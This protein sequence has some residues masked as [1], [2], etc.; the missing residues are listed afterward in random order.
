VGQRV[1]LCRALAALCG[2]TGRF[3]R[4]RSRA[5]RFVVWLPAEHWNGMFLARGYS[6]YGGPMD[7]V[8]LAE[9]LRLGYATA[10]TDGGGNGERG[11]SFLLR[12]REKLVDVGE[13]AR[14]ST[15]VVAKSLATSYYESAPRAAYFEG[16]GGAGR[17]GLKPAQRH[18]EDFDGI[19]VGGI[20]H[21]TVH[22]TFAQMWVWEAAH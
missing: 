19:A 13:R 15:V 21:D 3:R 8:V 20:A 14:H 5:V 6:F 10:T 2:V 1:G 11:A 7:P 9:A 18:P 16:C 4:S 22:F 17:Q 12:Q